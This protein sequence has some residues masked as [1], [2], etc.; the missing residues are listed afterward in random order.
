MDPQE[1]SV[2]FEAFANRSFLQKQS[3]HHSYYVI[4]DLMHD[5]AQLVSK[6]ECFV[7]KDVTDLDKVPSNVRHLSIFANRMVGCPELKSICSKKKLRSL[8]FQDYCS[9][10]QDYAPVL[11]C[12]FKELLRLRVL[13][14]DCEVSRLPESLGNS[15][16]LRYFSLCKRN[17]DL[18][19]IISNFTFPPSLCRLHQ[20]KIIDC[21]D[22]VIERFPPGFSDLIRLQKIKSRDF[23]YDR[24]QSD[25]L[26][27]RWSNARTSHEE[28]ELMFKQ[29]EALPHWNLQHLQVHGYR[30]ESF[31]SWLRPHLLPRL[32]SLE[33][34][35][36]TKIKSIAFFD[37][38]A[39][40][41]SDNHDIIEEL[42]I[43]YC[44]Q[45]Y[46]KRLVE[47]PTSLRKLYLYKSGYFMDNLVSRFRDLTSLTDL[48]IDDC[49]WLTV[50]PLDVWSSNLPSL[51][52]LHISR[53]G[54]LTSIGVS[55]A[56][57]SSNGVKG[58]SSLS[59]IH[60]RSCYKLLSLEEFLIPDY[61]PVVKTICVE[62][63]ELTSLSVDRLDGLQNLSI[64]SC[65]RLNPQRVMTFPSSL[66]ELLLRK[67]R[68]IETIN[69]DNSQLGS[70]PA[71]EK[72]TISSCPVLRSIGGATA[73]AKIQKVEISDCPKLKEIYDSHS[74]TGMYN[75]RNFNYFMHH[76]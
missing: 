5:M 36:C 34:V 41:G 7:I 40:A 42:A 66:K 22:Y 20:L 69:I 61:L 32:R 75:G 72:L 59:E 25:K 50:I 14:L 3:P 15:K 58:F 1:A 74:D 6:D 30:G 10:V 11:D 57:S 67:C 52:K 35:F 9:W 19:R 55:G 12:W 70:S 43:R 53:C 46:W 2:C 16:H 49:V 65:P 56:N 27:L 51:E 4:H 76:S 60:I 18:I 63:C 71:L 37:N 38:N 45:I 54:Q 8:V 31:P 26:S 62:S 73:V 21:G 68:R 23:N 47:V 39:G 48:Q 13:R 29:M 33:F 44:D 17:R 28:A 24:D 64:L